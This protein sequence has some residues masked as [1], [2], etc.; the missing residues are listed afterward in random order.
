MKNRVTPA[1]R[2]MR[3][4]VQWTVGWGVAGVV[5]GVPLMLLKMMMESAAR[6]DDLSFYA[7]WVPA[8]GLGAAAG[9]LGIG[10]LYAGLL[11]GTEEWRLQYEQD[12]RGVKGW[13]LPPVVC[14]AASGLIPGL[15]VG[16]IGGA[17]FFALLAGC[18]AAAFTRLERGR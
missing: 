4:A 8:L 11:M 6:A 9:G 1:Q 12:T 18:T 17:L 2:L 10:V 16:G 5:L 3:S 13:L 7:F 15:L 14:G